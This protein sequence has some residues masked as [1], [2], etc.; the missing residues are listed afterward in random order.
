MATGHVSTWYA[1]QLVFLNFADNLTK[2]E[3]SGVLRRLSNCSRQPVTK[4]L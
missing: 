1:G 4:T 3:I 2:T